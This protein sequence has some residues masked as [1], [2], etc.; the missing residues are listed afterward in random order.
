MTYLPNPSMYLAA[1]EWSTIK[2]VHLAAKQVFLFLG[3]VHVASVV[4]VVVVEITLF[5]I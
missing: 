3:L 2:Y 4:F 1:G 5:R